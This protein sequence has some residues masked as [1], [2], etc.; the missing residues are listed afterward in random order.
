MARYAHLTSSTTQV[1][2]GKIYS[3]KIVNNLGITGTITVVDNISGTTPVVAVITNPLAGDTFEYWG[4]QTGLRV[5]CS[6]T[7]D[8][9]VNWQSNSQAR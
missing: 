6:T 2:S 1:A 8:V 7:S 9:T 3:T 5:I 4:L